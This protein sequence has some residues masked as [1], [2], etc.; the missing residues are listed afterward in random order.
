MKGRRTFRWQRLKVGA[1]V[2]AGLFLL[3]Y[4]VYRVGKIFDVFAS[5]YSVMI[6]LHSVAGL[7]EGA[8]VTLAGQRVGQ[9][10]RIEFIPLDQK[11]GDENLAIE[12]KISREV[13]E[14]IRKD[15]RAFLRAQGLL[16]DKY[17]DISA[18]T[19]HASVVQEGDTLQ[20]EMAMDI[21]QFLA[22][23]GAVL[24]SATGAV[25]DVRRIT[26]GLAQ[27][28]GTLGQMLTNE[29]LYYRMVATTSQLHGTLQR[30]N[31]PNGTFGR[32][33]NDPALYNRLL[34][35]ITRVDSL[36]NA[37]MR[38]KGSL[39][40]LIYK[41]DLYNGLLSGVSQ[42]DTAITGFSGVLN[43]LSNGQGTL[44]KLATDARM[45]DEL[46]KAIVDLQTIIADMRAN[47]KKYVPDVNVK[48]F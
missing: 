43:R 5:R 16:G 33:M 18:G 9:V 20:S 36:G 6:L 14:Q 19:L 23:S 27:G 3:G 34:A 11:H 25:S 29:K 39:S 31:N 1:L 42:A 44:H 26:S 17:V 45:Y 10:K 21:E 2:V 24:D 38:G 12:L 40:K 37:V 30:F 22:R 28:E 15:S 13:Q 41:D 47:P 32:M 7:R 8:P 46:L 48:V 4:G 35:A